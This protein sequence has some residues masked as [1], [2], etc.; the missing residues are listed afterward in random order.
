MAKTNV[1][2]HIFLFLR[3]AVAVTALVWVFRGQNWG[4]LGTTFANLNLWYFAG[5]LGIFV[6]SQVIVGLRWWLLLRAQGIFIPCRAAVRLHF[7]GLFYNNFMPSSLGGDLIRAWY[8]TRHTD[9]RLEAALSVFVDRMIGLLGMIIIAVFCYSVFMRGVGSEV[10]ASTDKGGFLRSVAQYRLVFLWLVL[11]VAAVFCGL[12][13]HRPGRAMLRKAWSFIYIH[14]ARVI[15]KLT[16]AIILYCSRPITILAALALTIFVQMMVITAF[17]LLGVNLE[18]DADA[19]YYFVFF[20]MVWVL[21]ALPVS[22]GGLGVH[23]GG[24]R[25]LFTRFTDVGPEAVLVLA[26]CQR[27]IFILASLP[28]VVIHL[29]GAHLPKD[30]S[31]DGEKS[32]N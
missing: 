28:G 21:G 10:T 25:E 17:W 4:E 15:R 1:K 13:L 32:V 8:V 20:P 3:I 7:L 9:K 18:I 24:L 14:G 12:L 29:V 31:I 16:N 26:L 22:I 23:E 30:F 19:R 27:L 2:K 5:S 11:A 6:I